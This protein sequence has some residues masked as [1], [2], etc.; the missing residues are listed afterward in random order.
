[1][2]IRGEVGSVEIHLEY[3]GG[4][5][6]FAGCICAQSADGFEADF[7]QSGWIRQY[8]FLHRPVLFYR[9]YTDLKVANA[10]PR[11]V[12]LCQVKPEQDAPAALFMQMKA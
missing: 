2:T 8:T 1:R 6:D 12:A 11:G 10:P 3:G 5:K 9:V 4:G 7:E